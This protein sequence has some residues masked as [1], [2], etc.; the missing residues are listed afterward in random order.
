MN[1]VYS[2]LI[3]V[4]TPGNQP[5]KKFIFPRRADDYQIGGPVMRIGN[6]SNLIPLLLYVGLIVLFLIVPVSAEPGVTVSPKSINFTATTDSVATRTVIVTA[7]ENV[8]NLRLIPQDMIDETGA[9]VVHQDDIYYSHIMS[10]M[11]NGSIQ[12]VPVNFNLAGAPGGRYTGELWFSYSDEGTVIIPVTATIKAGWFLPLVVLIAGILVSYS[13]F[14]YG[15]RYK[16]RD[17]ITRMVEIIERNVFRDEKLEEPVVFDRSGKTEHNIF[18]N[19]ITGDIVR[20]REKLDLNETTEADTWLT[21]LQSSWDN[22]NINRPNLIGF[23]DSFGKLMVNLNELELKIV[24]K[25]KTEGTTQTEVPAI[26]ELREKLQEKC[27]AIKTGTEV[28]AVKDEANTYDSLNISFLTLQEIEKILRGGGGDQNK[29]TDDL[30]KQLQ[31]VDLDH[32]IGIQNKLSDELSALKPAIN[33]GQTESPGPKPTR[34]FDK[35]EIDTS[36]PSGLACFRLWLYGWG[37][38]V[39]TVIILAMAGFSQLYL[40]NPTFGASPGDWATLALWGL[41]VGPTADAVSE[42]AKGTVGL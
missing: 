23:Y 32:I 6:V 17:E 34:T 18:Y 27:T 25:G 10:T 12:A 11:K 3:M 14:C 30:W 35:L 1:D 20:I 39:V 22:W 8:T 7:V 26:K 5:Q 21:K 13:L 41:L 16:R 4:P 2:N 37:S 36:G 9:G 31:T 33:E 42:K 15:K 28:Q 29:K 24:N 38:F 19:Q 40:S